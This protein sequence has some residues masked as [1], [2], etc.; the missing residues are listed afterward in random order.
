MFLAFKVYDVQGVCIGVE[1][2][3]GL[4][5]AVSSTTH[6]T[7]TL[8]AQELQLSPLKVTNLHSAV[9]CIGVTA[10]AKVLRCVCSCLHL[11]MYRLSSKRKGVKFHLLDV[12]VAQT[13]GCV[14][15]FGAHYILGI[16]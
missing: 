9:K 16:S 13:T 15:D 11:Q 8:S 2:R 10:K 1:V 5:V 14:C 3:A 12:P 4:Y 7:A 6:F